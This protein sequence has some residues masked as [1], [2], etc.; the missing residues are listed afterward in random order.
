[1]KKIIIVFDSY[2]ELV[3]IST[4]YRDIINDFFKTK[5]VI[6]DGRYV[7]GKGFNTFI[8]E[9]R[10]IFSDSYICSWKYINKIFG[11]RIGI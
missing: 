1:M 6:V 7:A 2:D 11:K 10:S 9:D 8:N 5:G 4:M 3:S